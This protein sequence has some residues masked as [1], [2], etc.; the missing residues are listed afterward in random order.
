MPVDLPQGEWVPLE[1][2]GYAGP[3]IEKAPDPGQTDQPDTKFYPARPVNA[4]QEG[5]LPPPGAEMFGHPMAYLSSPLRNQAVDNSVRCC[6]RGFP[7]LLDIA[8]LLL[9]TVLTR[10]AQRPGSDRRPVRD[11]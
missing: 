4:G 3:V 6:R 11:R 2:V 8:D 9:R 5:I 1:Q 7:D 10:K